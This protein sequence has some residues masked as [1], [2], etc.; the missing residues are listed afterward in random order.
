MRINGVLGRQ[1]WSDRTGFKGCQ[2]FTLMEVLVATGLGMLVFAA[3][4]SLTLFGTRS[5]MAIANYSDLDSKSR[6]A[7]DVIGRELRQDST[8]T[9]LQN[10]S[11]N[12]VLT[13]TNA[14]Q[15]YLVNL[16]YDTNKRTVTLA[17]T[18]QQNLVALTECDRFDVNLFQRTPL[19]TATNILFYP[20]T[21]TSGV[22]TLNLA[23]LVSLDWKCSRQILA[24]KVNTESVQAAQIVLRNK[25]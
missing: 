24:Q 1:R 25:Q 15:G 16:T 23:K 18:G 17:R 21:N 8:V 12:T 19:V 9:G 11:T 22:L 3:I 20:A 13:L 7:L 10:T 6:Y 4:M 5:T 2:G 14:S